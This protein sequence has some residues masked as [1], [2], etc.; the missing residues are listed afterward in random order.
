MRAA[1]A[2]VPADAG[3]KIVDRIT[4]LMAARVADSSSPNEVAGD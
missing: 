4:A 2:T 3:R 1:A